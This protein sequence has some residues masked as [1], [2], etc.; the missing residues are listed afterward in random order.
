[1][2]RWSNDF[3]DLSEITRGWLG[4]YEIW[5]LG[6]SPAR[7]VQVEL[8]LQPAQVLLP[9]RH[10]LEGRYGNELHFP[11]AISP[12]LAAFTILKRLY[13]INREGNESQG[14]R[15][16]SQDLPMP[17]DLDFMWNCSVRAQAFSAGS[18]RP[19]TLAAYFCPRSRYIALEEGLEHDRTHKITMVRYSSTGTEVVAEVVDSLVLPLCVT[20]LINLSFHP[21]LPILAFSCNR[22]DGGGLLVGWSLWSFLQGKQVTNFSSSFGSSQGPLPPIIPRCQTSLLTY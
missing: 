20:P 2:E 12:N 11:I 8:H 22:V 14:A 13:F 7:I 17:L 1:M 18:M 3:I 21:T 16:L 15:C 9:L 6:P 4:L 19:R 10:Y 5:Q